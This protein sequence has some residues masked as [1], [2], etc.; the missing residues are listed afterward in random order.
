M[1]W[2][3]QDPQVPASAIEAVGCRLA[4]CHDGVHV[5][6]GNRLVGL[7]GDVK[8]TQ[9]PGG[10]AIVLGSLLLGHPEGYRRPEAYRPRKSVVR[11]I[12]GGMVPAGAKTGRWSGTKN[13]AVEEVGNVT[14]DEVR[15][16]KKMVWNLYS[17]CEPRDPTQASLKYQY[18]RT[19]QKILIRLVKSDAPAPAEPEPFPNREFIGNLALLGEFGAAER[20]CDRFGIDKSTVGYALIPS[21]PPET[22]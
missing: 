17:V 5:C 16:L 11:E 4:H 21:Q 9:T 1:L 18:L 3:N 22:R 13:P 7:F 12:I 10:P 15:I 2:N 20:L 8:W 6:R 19:A 14:P